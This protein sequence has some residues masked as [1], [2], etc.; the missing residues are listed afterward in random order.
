MVLNHFKCYHLM[1]LHF[2]G[3][4]DKDEQSSLSGVICWTGTVLMTWCQW[5][6][7]AEQTST[8]ACLSNQ[9]LMV[10]SGRPST[11]GKHAKPNALPQTWQAHVVL[12]SFAKLSYDVAYVTMGCLKQTQTY[13]LKITKNSTF[14]FV[15]TQWCH[16]FRFHREALEFTL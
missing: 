9:P 1:P 13:F 14:E 10:S 6:Q 11:G 15:T 2:K 7:P 12:V 4:T 3:L 5:P 8:I 16:P